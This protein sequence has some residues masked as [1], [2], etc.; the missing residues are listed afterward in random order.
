MSQAQCEYSTNLTRVQYKLIQYKYDKSLICSQ[1][2]YKHGNET[3]Q[4]SS[5]CAREGEVDWCVLMWVTCRM[6]KGYAGSEQLVEYFYSPSLRIIERARLLLSTVY[7]CISMQTTAKFA[8]QRL[9]TMSRRLSIAWLG[10]CLTLATGWVRVDY[11]SILPRLRRFGCGTRIRSTESTSGVSQC[12][13]RL[14]VSLTAYTTSVLVWQLPALSAARALPET[15]AKTLVQAFISCRLDYC[16]V[17]LYGITDNLFRRVQSIQNAVARLLTCTRRRNHISPVL[18]RLHCLAII[19]ERRN[20]IVPRGRLPACRWIRTALS[21]LGWRQCP[22]CPANQ[23]SAWRQEFFSGG[24]ESMEQ[25][26]RY[27]A[28]ALTL[29]S[30]SSNDF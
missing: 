4:Q 2:W 3:V 15:A 26:S 22:H 27:T 28:T 23:H 7:S 14:S 12:Y 30:A 10:A 25:S 20:A 13:R 17:L 8:W 21:S 19:A 1:I 6:K 29:N 18:S 16:N 9:S 11:V 5:A 24:P